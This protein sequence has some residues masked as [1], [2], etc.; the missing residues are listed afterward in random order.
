[1]T[2]S[3]IE[4]IVLL[5]AHAAAGIYS[6]TLKYSKKNTYLIWCGWIVFQI[7]LLWHAEFVLT[8]KTLQFFSG[9]ALPLIGQYA[10]FFATTKGKITQRIFTLLTYSIFFCISM[11]L[12]TMVKGTFAALHPGLYILI[13]AVLL[14]AVVSYFLRY[15]CPLCRAAAR[16]VSS[17]WSLLV[18]VN[19]I[20]LLAVIL[21]SIFPEKLASFSDRSCITFIFLSVS[22][23]T[24]YPVIFMSINSMS[25]AAT[26]REVERQNRL[27]LTQ[28]EV[29]NRQ[30]AADS[31]ARHDR[32]HHN[33][34]MFEFANQNDIESVREYLKNLVESES[35]IRGEKRFCEHMTVNTVL[36]VYERQA[37]EMGI[38]VRV[39]AQVSRDL[40][41]QPQDLVIVIA[42]L[43]ENAIHG[44]DKAKNKDRFIEVTIRESSKRLLV[45]VENACKENMV[46]DD[47]HY[48]IGI[49]SVI[50]T[51]NKYDGMYDFT[52]DGG[53]FA[54]K[55]SLNLA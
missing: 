40:E 7:I 41:I 19:I 30:L 4:F 28:I 47:S 17:G 22:I 51:T 21:S 6:S 48:G 12:F 31:Q 26:K 23:M 55:V 36:T 50:A 32:R 44:A 16:N 38:P 2:G 20:F 34:V 18:Y 39:S 53:I 1:M 35:G 46:F 10:I 8:N 49:R 43:F 24:V 25:E 29:E 42:N 54:A 15:V 3:I 45:R 52:A 14:F 11:T 9:F 5:L 37:Q 13:H 27:L 33:L